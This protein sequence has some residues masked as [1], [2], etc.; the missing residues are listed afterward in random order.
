MSNTF[1]RLLD[2]YSQ[3]ER[4]A[5]N[6]VEVLTAKL[7][8]IRSLLVASDKAPP[9]QLLDIKD[10]ARLLKVSVR[11]VE[12]LIASGDLVPMRIQS[13]RRFSREAVDAYLRTTCRR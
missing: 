7:Q 4:V 8:E 3:P 2:V 9:D 1:N 12:T 11:T 13:A 5:G 10:V 6:A